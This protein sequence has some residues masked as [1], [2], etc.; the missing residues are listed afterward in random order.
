MKKK[1][2]ILRKTNSSLVKSR[3][4]MRNNSPFPDKFISKACAMT[5]FNPKFLDTQKNNAVNI[6]CLQHF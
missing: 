5:I 4:K 6:C 1:H 2:D 3:L